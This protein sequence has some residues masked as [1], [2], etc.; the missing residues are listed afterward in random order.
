MIG[1][2]QANKGLPT[3]S[4]WLT[5]QATRMIT[6][7]ENFVNTLVGQNSGSLPEEVA[8]TCR[9]S[10]RRPSMGTKE[11]PFSTHYTQ[12][13]DEKINLSRRVSPVNRVVIIAAAV[14]AFAFVAAAVGGLFTPTVY[15]L[16]G[17][18]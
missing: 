10:L 13:P 5:Q 8:M 14:G 4:F 1:C 9:M 17:A 3:I 15:L 2:G 6:C 7:L 11:G 18:P 16:A 12:P